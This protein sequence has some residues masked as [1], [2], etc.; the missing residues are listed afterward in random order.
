[1]K[2]YEYKKHKI[3]YS[4]LGRKWVVV[5]LSNN[6]TEEFGSILKAVA[7]FPHLLALEPI[8]LAHTRALEKIEYK[9]K[10]EKYKELSPQPP[11]VQP[12]IKTRKEELIVNCYYCDGTGISA[13][14]K[15]PNC[16]GKG[17]IRVTSKGF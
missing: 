6:K 7:A 2:I 4:H 16:D 12:S 15:C 8:K 5:H 9:L 17:S 14:L 13:F 11:V 1:M 3:Y 10:N